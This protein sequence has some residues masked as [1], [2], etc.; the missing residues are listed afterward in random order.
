MID[1]SI[2]PA[3]LKHLRLR[4]IRECYEELSRKAENEHWTYQQFLSALCDHELTGRQQRRIER[5]LLEAKLPIGKSLDTFEFD[6]LTSV[7]AAQ[8]ASFAETTKWVEQAHNLILFGPSG[9]GK[10]HLA[11]AIGRRLIEKGMRVYFAK[12]T[13][14]VQAMQLA[15]GNQRLHNALEKLAKFDLL[16]LDDIG[17]VKKTDAE[18][19]VLFELIAER[20]ETKSLLITANQPFDKWDTIFPNSVMAVAAVDRLIHHATIISINEKSYRKQFAESQSNK[21]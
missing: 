6:K 2:L 15:Y 11:A 3:Q 4:A 1:A 21:Q 16:I 12:T 7:K 13:A 8:I 17:Y 14:L 10:T 19:S 5:H 20:Y 9:V 18:T